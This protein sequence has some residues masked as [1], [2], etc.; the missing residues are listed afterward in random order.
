MLSAGGACVELGH[1]LA[2]QKNIA[3]PGALGS[4]NAAVL[5]FA[6]GF[7]SMGELL[8]RLLHCLPSPDAVFLRAG[9]HGTL[10][11]HMAENAF[12][13]HHANAYEEGD[14]TIVLSSGWVWPCRRPG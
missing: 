11:V 1:I 7:S 12:L 14:E 6:V 9:V 4:C 3:V 8:A 5:K 10:Q 2:S 13:I